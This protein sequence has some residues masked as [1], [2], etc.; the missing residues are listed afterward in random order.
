MLIV[1][2]FCCNDHK[3]N[4]DSSISKIQMSPKT[5]TNW[6]DIWCKSVMNGFWALP[7]VLTE[8]M[9]PRF[10]WRAH[11]HCFHLRCYPSHCC[12]FIFNHWYRNWR[13]W[14]TNKIQT[15]STVSTSI[16][17][18]LKGAS[19]WARLLGQW[20]T[21][22]KLH[23]FNLKVNENFVILT[24]PL[25]EVEDGHLWD[26]HA[27]GLQQ[28]HSWSRLCSSQNGQKGPISRILW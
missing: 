2:S 17:V 28:Q 24:I 21:S 19:G 20:P 23:C 7:S 3:K 27:W 26:H 11:W 4:L 10:R 9:Q 25:I 22:K 13:C 6:N 12:F 18:P 15:N 16:N 8:N 5:T 1:N 14:S